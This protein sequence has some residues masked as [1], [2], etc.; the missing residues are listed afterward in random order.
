MST[1][2]YFSHYT[3]YVV[4][5]VQR[6][7]HLSKTHE[8]ILSASNVTSSTVVTTHLLKESL[9]TRK[10]CT[11]WSLARIPVSFSR[12]RNGTH[13]PSECCVGKS[14]KFSVFLRGMH[15]DPE[16]LSHT[17]RLNP[18]F[19]ISMIGTIVPYMYRSRNRRVEQGVTRGIPVRELDSSGFHR[20]VHNRPFW[21][22]L[23]YLLIQA[24]K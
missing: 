5:C 3:V 2:S 10:G 1:I 19:C 21:L 12:I 11:W 18:P 13:S 23:R 7:R 15:E 9:T 4:C 20:G 6:A 14:T 24:S 16:T 17:L 22:H 8:S